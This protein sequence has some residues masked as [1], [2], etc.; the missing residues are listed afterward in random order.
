MSQ[1]NNLGMSTERANLRLL[2]RLSEDEPS[3]FQWQHLREAE[4][5]SN[6]EVLLALRMLRHTDNA[7]SI[8]CTNCDSN[9][10]V[11]VEFRGNG[12]Y[13]AYCQDVGFFGVD[14]KDLRVLELDVAA[15]VDLIARG[16]GIPSRIPTE[17]I[18]PRLLYRLGVQRFGPYLTRLYFARCLDRTSCFDRAHSAL[19]QHRDRTPVILVSTTSWQRIHHE[20]PAR[21]ALV[22]LSDVAD[23][24]GQRLT[25]NDDAFLARLR[26]SDGAFQEGSIGYR[27]S[28]GFRSAVVGDQEYEFTK[29]QAEVVEI[30]F[31]AV[32]AGLRKVHQDEIKGLV[33][34]NQRVG[35]L[36]R[37]HPAYGTLI[38]GDD[39][40]FYWLNL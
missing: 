30:L 8:W 34:T 40:A 22:S 5:V 32:K 39:Q 15:L 20:L 7:S 27:F 17:E 3:S 4:E 13:R 12:V 29:K 37:D 9:H 24:R 23:L 31:E 18:V 6:L 16:L 14:P 21:H 11:A 19:V 10:S 1:T 33:N 26:G 28:P 36:F 2:E 35:Q 25:F 38:Q